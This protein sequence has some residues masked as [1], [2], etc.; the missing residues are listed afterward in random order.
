MRSRRAVM[1]PSDEPG[2]AHACAT[3]AGH[4]AHE[5]ARRMGWHHLLT[6]LPAP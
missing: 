2:L 5:L 4:T 6:L 3:P 1:A